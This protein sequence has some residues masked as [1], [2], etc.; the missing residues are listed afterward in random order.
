[1][2]YARIER[3]KTRWPITLP[4][5]VRNVSASGYFERRRRKDTGRPA[6]PGKRLGDEALL[7]HI[8]AAHAASKGGYPPDE[9]LT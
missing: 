6:T 8:K 4:C 1:M 7:V 5:E 9:S 3:H 2:K